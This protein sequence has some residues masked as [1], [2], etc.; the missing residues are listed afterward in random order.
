MQIG[1][2][3]VA[4][5]DFADGAFLTLPVRASALSLRIA[6]SDEDGWEKQ[7]Q[8]QLH[9]PHAGLRRGRRPGDTHAQTDTHRHPDTDT[10]AHA[11]TE[12]ETQTHKHPHPHTPT[13]TQ[14]PKPQRSGER[15]RERER[16][17][18]TCAS[19]TMSEADTRARNQPCAGTDAASYNRGRR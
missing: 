11:Q 13:H 2:P 3:K 1:D 12:T 16:P 17:S 19:L 8:L 9:A 18:G 5:T 4:L 14:K 7:V 15:E 6:E 10:D